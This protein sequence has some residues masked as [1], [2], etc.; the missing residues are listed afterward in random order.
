MLLKC[1]RKFGNCKPGDTVQVPDGAAFDSAFFYRVKP[2]EKKTEKE[3][4]ADAN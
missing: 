1:K 4:K 3:E 2:I